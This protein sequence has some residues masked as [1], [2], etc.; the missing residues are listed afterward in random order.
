MK[1]WAV[2]VSMVLA[3]CVATY[4]YQHKFAM[5][6]LQDMMI[7]SLDG[8]KKYLPEGGMIG[9]VCNVKQKNSTDREKCQMANGFPHFVLAPVSLGVKAGARKDTTLILS[10][11]VMAEQVRDNVQKDA[12]IVWEHTDSV[13][14]YVLIHTPNAP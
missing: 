3:I 6:G 10:D 7:A 12:V 5:P 9:F 11:A 13:F 14:H 1:T 4:M 8:A 2:H